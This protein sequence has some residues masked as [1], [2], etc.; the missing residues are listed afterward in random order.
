M[1]KQ[2]LSYLLASVMM[3][4]A[5]SPALADE[6]SNL[7]QYVKEHKEALASTEA[8]LETLAS[9]RLEIQSQI[10]KASSDL[11][12][13]M[14]EINQAEDDIVSAQGRITETAKEI[15]STKKNLVN[16][17]SKRDSQYEDMKKRIQYIY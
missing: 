7:E 6:Q 13:V 3:L 8:S 17:R 9:R 1:R 14:V 12:D 5:A 4:T 10:D 15:K 2:L 11:V 16:A